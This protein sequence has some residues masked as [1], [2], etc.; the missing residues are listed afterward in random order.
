M[1]RN[2]LILR[3]LYH[4]SGDKTL[5]GFART[6]GHGLLGLLLLLIALSGEVKAA[7][8]NV[9]VVEI[10]REI[11]AT[12]W[13]QV[14]QSLQ[15]LDQ[16]PVDVVLVDM[17]TYGGA[18]NFADSIRSA[19]VKVKKPIIC[20]IDVNAASAGALIALACDRIYMAQGSTIGAATVVNQSGEKAPDK[21]QSYLRA[22]MRATAEASGR[23][24]RIA[25]AMVD[26]DIAIEGITEKGNVITFSRSE[27]L[28]YGFCDG[29]AENFNQALGAENIDEYSLIRPEFNWVDTAVGFF[30]S[31]AVTSILVLLILGGLY[32]EL[33]SPGIGF[34]LI[35]SVVAAV[36]YF[37]PLYIEELAASW[38]ILLFVVGLALLAAE[39]F[40][41]PGFG[42]AGIGGIFCILT[43]LVLSL[44]QNDFFDFTGVSTPNLASALIS[45]FGAFVVGFFVI[46]F[47]GGRII[48]SPM[49]QKLVLS[50][51]LSESKLNVE[52]TAHSDP[53]TRK[54]D[55]I[56]Q[57]GEA[58][59]DLRPYGKLQLGDEV[60]TV[61]AETGVIGKGSQVK[62]VHVE[63]MRIVGRQ[64]NASNPPQENETATSS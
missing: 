61:V 56:G 15:L 54:S 32:F 2:S 18:V 64:V 12:A 24:P 27:A 44:L 14:S 41:I 17:N 34:P 4:L 10:R 37:L 26:E 3:P 22:K 29:E 31:P 57:M 19:F 21:Y 6:N 35:V 49:F 62:I 45:V 25:E 20:L 39:I 7:E 28:K 11:D 9:L 51:N 40:L 1:L 63:G 5:S 13:R 46:I 16:K 8:K 23:D 47:T 43:A 36:L 33:Q 58:L 38:E 53:G 42:F 48:D 60:Y 52:Q 50:S 55:L 59:T 30:S